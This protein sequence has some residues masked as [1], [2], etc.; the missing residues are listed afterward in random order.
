[1]K[2]YTYQLK[3]GRSVL[4]PKELSYALHPGTLN[5]NLD[6]VKPA[7]QKKLSI[8]ADPVLADFLQIA[9]DGGTWESP[10]FAVRHD[11]DGEASFYRHYCIMQDGQIYIHNGSYV[12]LDQ[13]LET[14]SPDETSFV[15][16]QIATQAALAQLALAQLQNDKKPA[17]CNFAEE[18][19]F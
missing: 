6:S 5:L 17:P 13:F 7:D 12:R 2:H 10:E 15:L 11:H 16:C 19:Y 3:D 8:I 9:I 18:D 4:S 14:A 1:M